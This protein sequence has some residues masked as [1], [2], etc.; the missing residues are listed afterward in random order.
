MVARP[1]AHSVP[2][3]TRCGKVGPVQQGKRRHRTPPAPP[4]PTGL[5]MR[6]G[7]RGTARSQ[8]RRL[9]CRP[10]QPCRIVGRSGRSPTLPRPAPDECARCGQ[11]RY[12]Q[13]GDHWRTP[14]RSPR[15][16]RRCGSRPAGRPSTRAPY[17]PLFGGSSPPRKTGWAAYQRRRLVV[18]TPPRSGC[19]WPVS[20]PPGTGSVGRQGSLPPWNVARF[21]RYSAVYLRGFQD[22]ER[23]AK[24]D[25]N[26]SSNAR[27]AH[28]LVC[29]VEVGAVGAE[30]DGRNT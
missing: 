14:A 26:R 8:R 28:P 22:V 12:R 17:A 2:S 27:Y 7:T 15:L 23:K 20:R 30:L 29:L 24:Q 10:P 9:G 13:A 16:P 6:R 4:P 1:A 18:P 19:L 25:A 21:A 5:E 11:A 3:R